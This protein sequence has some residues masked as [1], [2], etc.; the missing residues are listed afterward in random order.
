MEVINEQYTK[1]GV[2]VR[3]SF[4]SDKDLLNNLNV[5]HENLITLSKEELN[6]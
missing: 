3:R 2:N 4:V 6:R 5:L 1:F